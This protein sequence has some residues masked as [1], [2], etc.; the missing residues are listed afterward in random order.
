MG[1]SKR[2]GLIT[3]LISGT[4]GLVILVVLILVIVSTLLAAN[5]L[6]TQA[7]SNISISDE[8]LLDGVAEGGTGWAWLNSTG[9]QLGNGTENKTR[10]DFIIITIHNTTDDIGSGNYTVNGSGYLT[11]VTLGATNTSEYN[12]SINWSATWT[13][14]ETNWE[15][16]AQN[17]S[18]NLSAGIG[19]VSSKI[20][21]ILLVAAVV[22]LLG[23]LLLL[24]AKAKQSGVMGQPMGFGSS[25][26]SGIVPAGSEL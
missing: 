17:L 14:E 9:Y 23:V 19:N 11:N 24:Y 25:S 7:T 13:G 5:L 8:G 3:E 21:T 6:G 16:T 1:N 20:P 18:A 15:T 26:A 10:S 22:L 2:G 12:I 4:A